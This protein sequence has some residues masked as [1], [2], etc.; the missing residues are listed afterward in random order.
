VGAEHVSDDFDLDAYCA[1]VGYQGP[2]EPSLPVLQAL[3]ALQPAAI[4]FE[5]LDPLCG[6]A[7]RLDR[8]S[9]V[10]KLVRHRRGGYCFE[11]NELFAAALEAMG[12]AVTRLAARVRWMVPAERADSA[13]THKLLRVDIDGEGWLAD[14]GFGAH[15]MAAPI[16]LEPGL[17]QDTPAS[18][19]R[20][21][22]TATGLMLQAHL[23]QGWQDAYRL[24][25]EP[26]LPADYEIANWFT[27]TNPTSLFTGNLLA[28][29]LTPAGR[30]ALFN[31]KLTWRP[32]RGSAEELRIADA[33]EFAAILDRGFNI[34]PPVDASAIWARIPQGDGRPGTAPDTP[35]S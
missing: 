14:V 22:E 13:R 3:H 9:L 7:V 23:P 6:V 20:L 11:L 28:E 10:E 8:E 32:A 29:R 27:A 17:E 1:R 4:P 15:L 16:R 34:A 35:A 30:L 25:L 19:L 31:R 21:V 33:T 18:R 12:F 2:R 26:Q 5:N 24:T